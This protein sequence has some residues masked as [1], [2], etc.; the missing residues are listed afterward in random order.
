MSDVTSPATLRELAEIARSSELHDLKVGLTHDEVDSLA[1]LIEALMNIPAYVQGRC[2]GCHADL[3]QHTDNCPVAIFERLT[4][5]S[6]KST[7]KHPADRSGH[8]PERQCKHGVILYG[9]RCLNC[10]RE[11]SENSKNG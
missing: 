2:V 9:N 5:P 3:R 10:E 1:D 4:S 7:D 8:S 11:S 6:E